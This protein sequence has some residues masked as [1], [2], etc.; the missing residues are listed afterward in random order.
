[1]N[2]KKGPV[3]RSLGEGGEIATI[4]TL[5]TLVVMAVSSLVANIFL[6]NPQTI[7]TRAQ[8]TLSGMSESDYTAQQKKCNDNPYD[9]GCIGPCTYCEGQRCVFHELRPY[10]AETGNCKNDADC[11]APGSKSD[12]VNPINP[13]TTKQY[14]PILK[15]GN[16]GGKGDQCNNLSMCN[17]SGQCDKNCC[18]S[19]TTKTE[20]NVDFVCGIQNGECTSGLAW[21]PKSQLPARPSWCGTGDN[22]L[23]ITGACNIACC[24]KDSD[25]AVNG[26]NQVCGVPNGHCKD[27]GSGGKSCA[28]KASG[29]TTPKYARVCSGTSCSW[30]FCTDNSYPIPI[31]NCCDTPSESDSKSGTCILCGKSGQAACTAT[32]PSKT[33]TGQCIDTQGKKLSCPS[34]AEQCCAR[35]YAKKVWTDCSQSSTGNN[36]SGCKWYCEDAKKNV[37][38]CNSPDACWIDKTKAKTC[39]S[40]SLPAKAA[41]KVTTTTVS[42]KPGDGTT[43]PV[44]TYTKEQCYYKIRCSDK[45]NQNVYYKNVKESSKDKTY[46]YSSSDACEKDIG[47]VESIA[48][49]CKNNPPVIVGQCE[50]FYCPGYTSN[51]YYK[52]TIQ[53]DSYIGEYDYQYFMY[54]DD[55]ANSKSPIIYKNL[56]PCVELSCSGET[57]KIAYNLNTSKYSSSINKCMDNKVNQSYGLATCK[58]NDLCKNGCSAQVAGQPPGSSGTKIDGSLGAVCFQDGSKKEGIARTE[59]LPPNNI[60]YQPCQSGLMCANQA[61][62]PN[63]SNGFGTC[64]TDNN[65]FKATSL[66]NQL[67][68]RSC[69][70]NINDVH[71]VLGNCGNNYTWKKTWLC[72]NSWNACC[73]PT[74][75]EE[76]YPELGTEYVEKKINY[77]LGVDN[78]TQSNNFDK[79]KK[80]L[81]ICNYF[82]QSNFGQLNLQDCN[83]SYRNITVTDNRD[84]TATVTFNAVA[85]QAIMVCWGSSQ[86]KVAQMTCQPFQSLSDKT[87]KTWGP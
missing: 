77:N 4:L 30:T 57:K 45:E 29:Q 31:G 54:K 10:C 11:G 21:M 78:I 60:T 46:Y 34:V 81:I 65:T 48:E 79:L 74:K 44:G 47:R 42:P 26:E 20:N 83:V 19:G 82:S 61:G 76:K 24:V 22:K 8:T 49:A 37:V 51:K 58:D 13:D 33:N 6:N 27:S 2:N 66:N 64:Q 9:T 87:N 52:K 85:D 35:G 7:K 50:D 14:C 73:V 41:L 62:N 43:I 75:D 69:P 71:C 5:G 40:P 68:T 18:S 17:L 63:F 86:E 15:G 23:D 56:C 16:V 38:D 84:A 3:L 55:C 36:I 70:D 67:L 25:C 53:G 32:T 39:E 12:I 1:M 72:I 59:S 28:A 80:N